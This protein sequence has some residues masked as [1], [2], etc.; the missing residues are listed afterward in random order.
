[1][2]VDRKLSDVTNTISPKRIRVDPCF[3]TRNDTNGFPVIGG[4]NL[5][6]QKAIRHQTGNRWK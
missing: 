1:M 2:I 3:M 5:Q 4:F 6:E